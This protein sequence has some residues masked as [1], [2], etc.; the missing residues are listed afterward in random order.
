MS[1]IATDE[2]ADRALAA[3]LMAAFAERTG[4]SS[5]RTPR[6]YLWT[7]AFAVCNFLALAR[8]GDDAAAGLADRLVAQVHRVLGRHR[9]DDTRQG[10]IS[11]L[12]EPD[13]MQRPTA[14]GLRIGKPLPERGPLQAFEPALEWDRDGQYFHYLTRWMHALDQ[15]A[16]ARERADADRWACELAQAAVD[17]FGR[18]SGGVR[19][20]WKMSI[21]LRRALV[22]SSGQHDALDGLV[23]CL[24]LQA[25]RLPG[26]DAPDLG[27]VIDRLVDMAMAGDWHTDDPLGLGGLLADAWRLAQVPG[28]VAL[29]QPLLL[30]MLDAAHAGLALH[31]REQTLRRPFAQRLAFRE[32][33][34]AIGLQALPRMASTTAPPDLQSPALAA[35][36][37]ALVRYAPLASAITDAWRDPAAQAESTWQ[38]HE[39]INAVMLATSLMP[40]GYL[41]L[42]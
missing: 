37:Q 10:W 12:S 13:G 39:D 2:P 33:G 15:F 4:L 41:D 19:L 35:R 1:G 11:G 26:V 34:L 7:D 40:S 18:P 6:R 22:P 16:H 23:T 36:V 9:P 29:R 21:D 27:D 25:R 31:A 38:A 30:R 24:Q 32:L 5:H 3:R 14:G 8:A 17:A 28:A 20:V 42:A